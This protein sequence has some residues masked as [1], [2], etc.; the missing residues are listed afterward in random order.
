MTTQQLSTSLWTYVWDFVDEGYNAVF[1]RVKENGIDSVS[2]ATAYHTGK[3]LLPHNPRRTVIFPED[4]TVYFQPNEKLYGRLRPHINSLVKNGSSLQTIKAFADKHGIR[5][6]AWV[7][8]CHNTTFGMMYPDV[9]CETA[10]GDKLFHNLCPTNNDVRKYITSLVADVAST[11]ID[12][13]ELEAFQFQGYVHGFHHE[14]E[15]VTLSSASRFLLGLCFCPSCVASAKTVGVEIEKIR[16]WTKTTLK[17][18]FT[19]PVEIPGG[20]FLSSLPQDLFSPFFQWRE[21]VINSFAEEVMSAAKP[22]HTIIRPMIT[23]DP[24]GWLIAGQDIKA[25]AGITG[26]VLALGYVKEDEKLKPLIQKMQSEIPEKEIILGVHVGLPESGGKKEFLKRM[27]AAQACG[28]HA[29]N[30]YNYSF[31]PYENLLWIKEVLQK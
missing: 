16:S 7:V 27:S 4:G 13:I 29:F 25:L 23:I 10:F 11:G 24:F 30:F 5:T 20:D 3:F 8:C 17:N 19:S 31:I 18:S 21:S 1:S 2:V 28:I 9:A 6:R 14:R 26:G 22:T 12:G 15:G